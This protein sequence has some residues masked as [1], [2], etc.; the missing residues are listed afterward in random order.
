MA[1]V[2]KALIENKF[3]W[4]VEAIGGH[5]AKDYKDVGGFAIDHYGSG[6]KIVQILNA[7]GGE[8]EPFGNTRMKG[9]AFVDALDLATRAIEYKNSTRA[10]RLKKQQNR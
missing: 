2:S 4:F 9:E 5:L 1:K 8:A 7:G 10:Q 3:R 6:Y